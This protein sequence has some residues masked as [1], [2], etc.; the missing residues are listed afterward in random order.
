MDE[1]NQLRE[2]SSDSIDKRVTLL[3]LFKE[4]SLDKT[5]W[6]VAIATD[7]AV[8]L[9]DYRG[10]EC[11]D[12]INYA[13]FC[14]YAR[15]G[16][17]P[18]CKV[19]NATNAFGITQAAVQRK[20]FIYFCPYGLLMFAIPIIVDGEFIGGFVGGQ[21]RCDDA[22]ADTIH[23]K[24]VMPY[25]EDFLDDDIVREKYMQTK[26]IP[27]KKYVSMANL[28]ESYFQ[29]L[30]D[31]RSKNLS[32]VQLTNKEKELIYERRKRRIAEKKSQQFRLAS[33]RTQMNPYFITSTMI[34]ISNMAI[35]ENAVMTNE[36]I[37]RFANFISG[38]YRKN[39]EMIT[40]REEADMIR[41]Y[42]DVYQSWLGDRLDYS[43]EIEEKLRSKKLPA[44]L[45]FTLVEQAVC[46]T[47][48]VPDH[49]TRIDVKA[50]SAGEYV[51]ILITDNRPLDNLADENRRMIMQQIEDMQEATVLSGIENVRERM[52]EY[53]GNN[54]SLTIKEKEGSVCTLRFPGRFEKEYI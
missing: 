19:S 30:A 38:L 47:V 16:E 11:T 40:L 45:V 53:F 23:L 4:E 33:M 29:Q 41:S 9:A 25:K 12:C 14:R 39:E 34:A 44:M 42:L 48:T 46:N 26:L 36:M 28:M 3:S 37:H 31:K 51:E 2:Q 13:E 50:R 7:L 35:I 18:I 32:Q 8:A 5:L 27:F 52:G 17:D 1:K 22:P 24:N 10:D 20:P 21:V 49:H 6:Q 43:I 54:G 15:E